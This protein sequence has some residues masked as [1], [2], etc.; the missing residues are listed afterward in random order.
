MIPIIKWAGGKRKL[1]PTI[2]SYLGS[3]YKGYYEPFAGGAAVLFYLEPKNAVCFDINKELINFYNTIK[4]FPQELANELETFFYPKHSKDF[5]YEVRGWDRRDD[6]ASIPAIKR[7]ARFAYLN[8]C[9]YNGLWRENNAGQNNVPW[10]Y[11][12]SPAF[13][14]R[15]Q[16]AQVSKYFVSKNV[17]FVLE[18]YKG[19]LKVAKRGDLVYFDP[20]YD[21]EAGVNGFVGYSASGFCHEQQTELKAICDA[22]IKKGVKVAISNSCTKFIKELYNDERYVINILNV[23]RNIGASVESR[24]E[25]EEVLIIGE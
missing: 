7:A 17:R 16:I 4:E 18:D 1:S 21:V 13:I 14:T 3:D 11:H 15:E 19:V 20:P 25:Y 2:A 24:K 8:K 23:Q 10:G 6:F 9:C 12:N 5:Y 22:L